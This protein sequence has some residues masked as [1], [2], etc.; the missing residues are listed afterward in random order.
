MNC[1]ILATAG[2]HKKKFHSILDEE[3]LK[4]VDFSDRYSY[5]MNKILSYVSMEEIAKVQ[6]AALKDYMKCKIAPSYL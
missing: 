6:R 3:E 2:K 5:V 4:K 1:L